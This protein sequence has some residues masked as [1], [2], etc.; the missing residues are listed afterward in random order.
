MGRV[1]GYRSYV[2][3]R[4]RR[5]PLCLGR[6][7]RRFKTRWY[8][9]ETYK[10]HTAMKLLP[11]L[12]TKYWPF[13]ML[14][15]SCSG[16]VYENFCFKREIGSINTDD[17][18]RFDSLSTPCST[19]LLSNLYG[20]TIYSVAFPKHQDI[21]IKM[22]PSIDSVLILSTPTPVLNKRTQVLGTAISTRFNCGVELYGF[23]RSKLINV[24]Y[25]SR[26][27][28]KKVAITEED[29]ES[30]VFELNL[31]TTEQTWMS[32][33]M[34]SSTILRSDVVK[35]SNGLY[36]MFRITSANPPPCSTNSRDLFWPC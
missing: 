25:V 26:T 5:V 8:G 16:N 12:R 34:N 18:T 2:K 14:L 22:P 10:A 11:L 33:I 7:L 17:F 28:S 4:C 31:S 9:G 29:I 27:I 1:F 20:D 23:E 24:L 6:P 30:D 36:F 19:N 21:I 13:V 32:L 35:T 15:A 3:D